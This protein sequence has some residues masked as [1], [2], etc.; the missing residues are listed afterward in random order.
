MT[1]AKGKTE[2]VARTSADLL[3]EQVERLKAVFPECVAEGKVDFEELKAALGEIADDSPERYS[4]TWAGKRDAIRL[5]QVPSRAT[6]VPCRKESVNFE[7]TKHLFIEGD[8]LEVLKLLYRAYAGRVKMIYIDPPY[9]TGNDFIYPDNFTD[10]LDTY[11][12]LTGQKDSEGNVL[13]SNPETSGRYHSAWLSMM[14]P[15]LFVAR[16]L[17]REDGVLLASIGD[18]ELANLLCIMNEVFGE[19]N[20][21]GT[22]LWKSRAKPT[23]AGDAIYRPQRVGEY[24]LVYGRNATVTQFF[25]LLSGEERSYPHADERGRY[26]TTTILTSNRGRYR[27]E[28]MRF[29]AGGFTPPEHQRWK[30]GR[31]II[32][33]LLDSGHIEFRDG[34]PFRKHYEDEE[35]AE[36]DPLWTYLPEEWTGT[37]ESGKA[38]LSELVGPDHGLDS[39]KPV[40][41]IRLFAEAVTRAG[42][43][44][45]D[46]F[47]GSCTTAQAVMQQNHLPPSGART[48][49]M[50]QLPEPTDE[51]SRPYLAAFKTVADIGKARMRG[52]I[53]RLEEETEGDQDIFSSQEPPEDLGFRVFKLNESH[54]RN[55]A[56]VEEKDEGALLKRMEEFA[57]PLLPGWKPENVIWEVAIKEG[58]SLS[59]TIERLDPQITQ[60]T[61]KTEKREQESV[62]SAR[63]ADNV[64]W[65]V[66]DPDRDQSFLICLDETLEEATVKALGLDKNDL[67]VCRDIALTDDLAANLAL[68]CRLKTI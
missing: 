37:A 58:F 57:D 63:S 31:D 51:G 52:V 47:A 49:V 40:G 54:Y 33:E 8:N 29:D 38:E 15:R 62:K 61:Q 22:F 39:V 67:F 56:G 30:A 50:I 36:H 46:F 17:L 5:L 48:F 14:Y 19:E 55:W 21:L 32:Q 60:M 9:N 4:F 64:V 11:L 2:S 45:M 26:R 44:V 18:T 68:Q 59:S 20:Q 35:T 24:V 7:D 13:T 3:A 1:R 23:N 65:R 41:L 12:Q 42:D 10:P 6:L 25:P 43:I 53:A 66:T 34:I 28:T 16:Q 27:R